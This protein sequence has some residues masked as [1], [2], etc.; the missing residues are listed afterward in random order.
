[1]YLGED[2]VTEFRQTPVKPLE[3]MLVATTQQ[4]FHVLNNHV[5]WTPSFCEDGR[6]CDK[7]V[8][9]IV[10]HVIATLLLTKA[11]AG[12]TGDE[13]VH[14]AR[15][16]AKVL[17]HL[18]LPRHGKVSGHGTQAKISFVGVVAECGPRPVTGLRDLKVDGADGLVS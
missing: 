11:S 17:G 1:V 9:P 3:M 4:L 14:V 16:E 12:R 5:S 15:A 2:L 7:A 18:V 8:A 13:H 6:T 10:Q